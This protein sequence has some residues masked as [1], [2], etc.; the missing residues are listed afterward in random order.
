MTEIRGFPLYP[1]C[2]TRPPTLLANIMIAAAAVE[3]ARAQAAGLETDG[4]SRRGTG[5][6]D[7][8]SR[9]APCRRARRGRRAS[10]GF[11]R[12]NPRLRLR[13]TSKA[14]E[15]VE[16]IVASHDTPPSV[17]RLPQWHRMAARLMADA[18]LRVQRGRAQVGGPAIP[19]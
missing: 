18:W 19:P 2:V 3:T 12:D 9:R 7:R 15:V 11:P 14:R 5:R 6:C 17:W 10:H 1:S 8:A 4:W 13:V 16:I